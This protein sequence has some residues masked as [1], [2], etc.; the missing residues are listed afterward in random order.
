MATDKLSYTV[1]VADEMHAD[2]IAL[3]RDL[4][5]RVILWSDEDYSSWVEEADGICNRAKRIP[6]EDLLRSKK[7]RALSKQGVGVDTI[8]LEACR[9]RGIT[10]C[11]TP[12]INAEA[13]AELSLG[14]AL[15]LLR[16]ITELDRRARAGEVNVAT[17]V[18]GRSLSGKVL[19]VVGMGNIGRLT[20]EKFQNACDCS[21]IAYDPFAPEDVW[22]AKGERRAIQ[23]TR[24]DSIEAML[25][26]V[27][28]LSLHLPLLPQTRGL[29]N[30]DTFSRMKREAIV[31]NAA[32]GG[33]INEEDLY[34][35]LSGNIIAGAA[36]DAL[37]TEPPTKEA[38]GDNFYKLNNIILCPHVGAS[39]QE[40]QSHSARTVVKQLAQLLQGEKITNIVQ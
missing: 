34:E 15:S 6:S 26:R 8:D 2:G 24:V 25:D 4:F 33:I 22:E 5:E 11:N 38:Y 27:D 14:L 32:R 20:A 10:V 17:S 30:K 7:V 16:R 19:G 3:A 18:M 29:I 31:I 21:V 13:V 12:G 35:A 37:E 9:K 40:V 36:L 28:V 23:H 1:A 39:T